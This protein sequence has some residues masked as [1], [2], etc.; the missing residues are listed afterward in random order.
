MPAQHPESV[1]IAIAQGSFD[2]RQV[3]AR[4][5][6][7]II[8]ADVVAVQIPVAQIAQ[9]SDT[10]KM[11]RSHSSASGAADVVVE[12]QDCQGYAEAGSPLSEQWRGGGRT[13]GELFPAR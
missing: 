9:T 6:I 13:A 4:L 1:G 3:H 5:R 10:G 2:Q 12:R 8:H 7:A 11:P